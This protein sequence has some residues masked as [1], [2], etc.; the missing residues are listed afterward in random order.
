MDEKRLKLSEDEVLD[1]I[2]ASR[3]RSPRSK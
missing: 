1:E 2:A 3:G